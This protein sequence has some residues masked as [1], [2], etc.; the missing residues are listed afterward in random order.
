MQIS[1]FFGQ[2]DLLVF[3]LPIEYSSELKEL[4]FL[5][6][7]LLAW[8][9]YA[10]KNRTCAPKNHGLSA[11]YDIVRG[12]ICK[13]IDDVN[14]SSTPRPRAELQLFFMPRAGRNLFKLAKVILFK[15]IGLDALNKYT[16]LLTCADSLQK[17]I[18]F[19]ALDCQARLG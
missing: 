11:D 6:E 4:T 16:N 3:E 5:L 10:S 17:F 18:L 7:D 8:E 13:S 2:A 1:V 19:K 15:D 14:R 9:E 12:P